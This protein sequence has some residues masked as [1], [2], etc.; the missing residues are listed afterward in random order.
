MKTLFLKES[1]SLG[2][3][4]L[5]K[6]YHTNETMVRFDSAP[7][8]LHFHNAKLP[9]LFLSKVVAIATQKNMAICSIG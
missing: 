9:L 7:A 6:D 2:S 8:Y 5:V 4:I 1:L 3:R